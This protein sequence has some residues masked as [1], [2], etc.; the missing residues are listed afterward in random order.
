M[1]D[2]LVFGGSSNPDLTERICHNLGVETGK[3]VLGKFSNGETQVM[4]TDSVREKDVYIIQ[5]GCGKAND[6]LM[7]L[8]VMISACKMASAKRITAVLPLFPYSR[9]PDVKGHTKGAP[10]L[11]KPRIR[12]AF[13]SG[14][15]TPRSGSRGPPEINHTN[16]SINNN[17]SRLGSTTPF[18][19]LK[20]N[21]N[22]NNNARVFK[23][24]SNNISCVQDSQAA[25]TVTSTNNA[26]VEFLPSSS[27]TTLTGYKRWIAQSGTLIANLLTTAGADHI[28]TMDLHDPQFQGFFDIPVDNLY[29][30]P[31]LQ[32][33]IVNCIPEY[34]D[35][36]IVSPD[37]GGA[38]RAM[39]LADALGVPIALIHKER[40]MKV[41]S[42]NMI[43]SPSFLNNDN[44]RI[45]LHHTPST[46]S[47]NNIP[48]LNPSPNNNGAGSNTSAI[49]STAG[50][51][52]IPTTP[53]E[54]I[55]AT[56]M[57]VGDVTDKVCILIDDLVDT[58]HTISRAAK[59]LKDQSAS[60]VYVLI[61]HGLFS[62]DAIRRIKHSGIDKVITT[63]SV[64]QGDH[65]EEFGND[66]IEVLDVSKILSESIRRINNGESVSML[67][68]HG[69]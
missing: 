44:E 67:F 29:S 1:R 51:S 19:P 15:S 11:S 30:K 9:Q 36:V 12:Y 28:I 13:E 22:N 16:S 25:A 43:T 2:L 47:L 7:E 46:Q 42:T 54:K 48:L 5:S 66:M 3:V 23:N 26:S 58:G 62:D 59:L 52:N 65:V 33:Y 64:P 27:A 53:H 14:V 37:S 55:V 31:L 6:N 45:M 63:N 10:L 39:A 20:D 38:K 41:T 34:Q 40:R 69:W 18:S 35:S 56:T 60:K 61:T 68:D 32:H 17:S 8:L 49:T 24:N 21:T 50:N 4:M 57:L